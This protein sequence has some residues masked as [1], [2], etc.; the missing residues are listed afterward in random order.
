MAAFGTAQ[1][2]EHVEQFDAPGAAV[3]R[4]RDHERW[5]ILREEWEEWKG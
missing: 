2:I 5:A 4:W 1:P 3:G